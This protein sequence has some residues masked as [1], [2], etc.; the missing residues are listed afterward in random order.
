MT[1][2]VM[3]PFLT[4]LILPCHGVDFFTHGGW[5]R[6]GGGLVFLNS[7]ANDWSTFGT[8]PTIA[9]PMLP[10]AFLTTCSGY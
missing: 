7:P 5:V 6:P 4:T 3:T 8:K 2:G 9:V 10:S 1:A